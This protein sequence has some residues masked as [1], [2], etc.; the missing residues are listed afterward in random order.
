MSESDLPTCPR[1][2]ARQARAEA[3]FC[4]S[5]GTPLTGPSP[6]AA[7]HEPDPPRPAPRARPRWRRR[8]L[9]AGAVVAALALTAAGLRT[10]QAAT[11]SPTDPVDD[12]LGALADG[13]GEAVLEH[14][15]VDSLLVLDWALAEGYTPPEDLRATE[16]TYGGDDA[17]TQRPD[18]GSATVHVEYELEGA[19]HTAHV[20]VTREDTGWIR[21]WQIADLGTLLG[22]LTVTSAHVDEVRVA[23]AEVDTASPDQEA[24][25]AT[26]VPALPGTYT[27]ATTDEEE[28]FAGDEALGEVTVL[29]PSATPATTADITA[30]DLTVR[31]G[32]ADEVAEQVEARLDECAQAETLTPPGCPLGLESAPT[33]STDDVSWQ[34]LEM[35][36][37]DLVA[38]DE[39]ALHGAPLE[40][41]TTTPGSAEAEWTYAYTDDGEPEDE[42][43]DVTVGGTVTI[44]E[45]GEPAWTP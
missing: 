32:L 38:S 12:L 4:R 25:A 18:R 15:E 7:G 44:D 45:D 40:V 33:R 3:R 39:E 20:R 28:L 24:H 16:V 10:V 19:T 23:G 43:V 42:T 11:T 13:H 29:G 27:L 21:D 36:E 17:D 34:I 14:A 37:V 1:C 8:L 5:C 2:H 30:E 22:E 35:P 26:G 41:E 6:S 9:V 31:E